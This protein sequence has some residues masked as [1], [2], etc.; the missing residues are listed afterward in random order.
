MM[1]REL[2][3]LSSFDQMKSCEMGIGPRKKV[4]YSIKKIANS[5]NVGIENP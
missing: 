3:D 2:R 1:A 5:I 4:V